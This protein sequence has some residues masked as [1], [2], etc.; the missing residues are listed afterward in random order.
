M[1]TKIDCG[2]NGH[3]SL[4]NYLWNFA[5]IHL[6]FHT[7]AF[8]VLSR[9]Y[10][11]KHLCAYIADFQKHAHLAH[12]PNH[13]L[14]IKVWIHRNSIC[15]PIFWTGHRANLKTLNTELMKRQWRRDQPE[16]KRNNN[17]NLANSAIS[18]STNHEQTK[19]MC[20][21]LKWTSKTSEYDQFII[22]LLIFS[23]KCLCQ[24]LLRII[25]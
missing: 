22:V 2:G 6:L 11:D 9:I 5:L 15:T 19:P 14:M 13:N 12:K 25:H 17:E 21:I 3:Q 7:L 4:I 8:S 18:H 1:I 10:A 16:V 23:L 20:G 24:F